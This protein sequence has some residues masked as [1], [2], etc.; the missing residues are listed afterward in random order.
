MKIFQS[1]FTKI[2]KQATT[3]LK[4]HKKLLNLW[5]FI[6]LSIVFAKLWKV[7]AAFIKFF[8]DSRLSWKFYVLKKKVRN[9]H[10]N[11]GIF[12]MLR[13][14]FIRFKAIYS[15]TIRKVSSCRKASLKNLKV[16]EW[17]TLLWGWYFMTLSLFVAA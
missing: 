3:A 8:I 15:K 5:A 1:L 4:C 10:R 2:V 13:K 14:S 9:P 11:F 6:K 16:E 12:K 17:F 7:C